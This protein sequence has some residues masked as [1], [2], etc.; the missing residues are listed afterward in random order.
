MS[1]T[2]AASPKKATVS[3][4]K[5]LQELEQIVRKLEEGDLPLEKAISLYQKGT[6]HAKQCE[7]QLATAKLKIEEARPSQ[8]KDTLR[9]ESL[10]SEE[11][12]ET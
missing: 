6:A 5:S 11:S 4:E 2:S 9:S 8:Q 10:P 12:D 1:S 7:Q 3:F